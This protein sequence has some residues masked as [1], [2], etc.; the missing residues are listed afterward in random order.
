MSYTSRRMIPKSV[1][2]TNKKP[3]SGMFDRV[4][5]SSLCLLLLLAATSESKRKPCDICNTNACHYRVGTA[6]ASLS[7][8]ALAASAW[9]AY[10]FRFWRGLRRSHF[11]VATFSA[12]FSF[13]T[14]LI[15][16]L[17]NRQL[18]DEVLKRF[19]VGL[20]FAIIAW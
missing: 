11:S 14:S 5:S 20:S 19:K 9:R 13:D 2:Q 12:I 16:L 3:T 7:Q 4:Q 17:H 1:D 18:R 8:F 10:D 6:L 15:P